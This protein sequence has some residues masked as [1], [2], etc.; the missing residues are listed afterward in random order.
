MKPIAE[1]EFAY[2]SSD[3]TTIVLND[4]KFRSIIKTGLHGPSHLE[5]RDVV[6]V[7]DG[8]FYRVEGKYTPIEFAL[9]EI[10]DL[11]V[12]SKVEKGSIR[13]RKKYY[14]FGPLVPVVRGWYFLKETK[15]FYLKTNRLYVVIERDGLGEN[16]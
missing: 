11:E 1:S 5:I 2:L 4:T 9:D 6:I 16:E 3:G 14:L 12:I 15:P 7:K 13:Y 8:E 10:D